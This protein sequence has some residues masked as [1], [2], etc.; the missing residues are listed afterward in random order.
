MPNIVISTDQ[1]ATLQAKVADIVTAKGKAD[2]ATTAANAAASNLVVAQQKA[3]DAAAAEATADALLTAD[4]QD[5]TSF[6]ESLVAT[7]PAAP[8]PTAAPT[9]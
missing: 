7:A 2:D 5:L 6:V 4:V 1:L 3:S 9:T 8:A